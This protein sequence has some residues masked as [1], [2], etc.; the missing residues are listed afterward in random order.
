MLLEEETKEETPAEV[1]MSGSTASNNIKEELPA[2]RLA[3]CQNCGKRVPSN[4]LELHVLRCKPKTFVNSPTKQNKKTNK[5]NS[6]GKK[7]IC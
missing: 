6:A 3:V 7:V 1:H 4:N 5:N 2:E